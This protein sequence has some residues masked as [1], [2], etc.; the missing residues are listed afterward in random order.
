VHIVQSPEA[1][2]FSRDV[3]RIALLN[4]RVDKYLDAVH[5]DPD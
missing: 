3:W 1:S 2:A 5:H 4:A